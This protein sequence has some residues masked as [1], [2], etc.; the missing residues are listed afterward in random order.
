MPTGP[1]SYGR[2]RGRPMSNGASRDRP[3]SIGS[4]VRG[5]RGIAVE[6]RPTATPKVGGRRKKVKLST[7]RRAIRQYTDPHTRRKDAMYEGGGK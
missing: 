1:G 2:K 7:K 3:G 5:T 4:S 6:G